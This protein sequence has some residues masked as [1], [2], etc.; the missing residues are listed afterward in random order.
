MPALAPTLA[1]VR[2]SRAETLPTRRFGRTEER[3]P[4]LGLG[5]GPAGFGL[6]DAEAVALYHACL[7]RGVTYL[8]TAPGY[9][10]AHS[11][12]GQVLPRR[13][14]EVFLATKCWTATAAE[15]VSIHEQSLRDLRVDCADLLYA[16]CVGSFT[17]EQLLAPDGVFAGLR[18]LQRRGLTRF[19]GFTSH[20]NPWV[21][22]A[23]L[24]AVER[25]DLEVDAVM[26]AMNYADRHTYGFEER[27][28]PAAQRLDLGVACMKVFGGA[29]DMNYEAHRVSHLGDAPH[30]PA[31]RYA[32][33]LPGVA[34]AVI[35]MY[36]QDELDRNLRWARAWEPLT[37]EEAERLTAEGRD[38][39][40]RWGPHF[41]DVG[42]DGSGEA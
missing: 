34:V 15:A 30:H 29:R 22:R 24:T 33:G 31:F 20:H 36:T 18:A 35:G 17:P 8:D 12:L 23:L 21:S 32:L 9:A 7:D 11:H 6:T 41:G 28:L 37:G 16:H 1:P 25:G 40:A 39:A 5:T 42:P 10:R 13:R 38:L 3:V 27:V 26:L 4:V 14:D 19:I 2:P